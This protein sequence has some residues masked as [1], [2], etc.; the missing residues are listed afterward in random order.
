MVP[1]K[2][3]NRQYFHRKTGLDI[4][5]HQVLALHEL[6]TLVFKRGQL[7]FIAQVKEFVLAKHQ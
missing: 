2:V 7:L 6:V 3:I 5:L 1:S 4:M